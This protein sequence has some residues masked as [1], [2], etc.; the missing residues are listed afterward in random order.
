MSEMSK[1]YALSL[2]SLAKD[3]KAVASYKDE[4]VVLLALIKENGDYQQL[5]STPFMSIKKRL[6]LCQKVVRPF[7]KY[8]QDFVYV[9]V[10]NNRANYLVDILEDFIAQANEELGIKQGLVYSTVLLD[11]QELNAIEKTLSKIEQREVELKNIIDHS[12]IGGVKVVIGDKIYDG[13]IKQKIKQMKS[14]L[15]KDGGN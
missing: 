12:L 5:L 7:R 6:L 15:L 10:K 11:K 2:L 3:E 14:D 4:V 9:I 8:I 13:S 1:R